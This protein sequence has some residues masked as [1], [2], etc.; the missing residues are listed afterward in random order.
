MGTK[1]IA[2][3]HDVAAATARAGRIYSEFLEG[4]DDR[5]VAPQVDRESLRARMHGTIGDEGIGLDGLLDEI[6]SV[7]LPNAMTTPHP[8]YAGLVNSSP[9]PAAPIADLIVSMLNNNGGAYHQSPPGTTAEEEVVHA[10]CG[11]LGY[12]SD[13]VGLLLPGGTFANLHGLML[14]RT[15]HFPDWRRKGPEA[16]RTP[17]VYTS[18]AAHFSI[19][20]TAHVLG[21]GEDNVVAIPTVGRGVLDTSALRDQIVADRG[22][23]ATPF[24]VV[25]TVGTTGTG[26]IDDLAAIADVCGELDLWLHVDACYG[27]AAALLE[28]LKPRFAG[29][30]RA[31]SLAIDPH[32]WFFQPIIAGLVMTRRS[33]VEHAAF[34]ID[35]SYIP[36]GDEP[37]S[38]VRAIPTSRRSSGLMVWAGLRAHGWNPIRDAVRRNIDQMRQLEARFASAGFRVLPDGELSIACVR[39][40]P[41]GLSSAEVD[42]LQGEIAGRVVESGAAW[43]ST[44]VHDGMTWMRFNIVNLHTRDAHVARIADAVIAAMPC[45]GRT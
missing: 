15:A 24:A 34:G 21:I 26:A 12:P 23:G 36:T 42:A 20:R 43:F 10:F 37:D 5:R 35:V 38:F 27:G 28:E 19:A 31:D 45:T 29:I 2:A 13:A 33:E 6:E 16:A 9:L 40:E 14:A 18:V 30:E 39:L 17:R 4:L 11:V 44:T 8:C 1:R 41:D 32:K 22:A 3:S 25:A 7:I